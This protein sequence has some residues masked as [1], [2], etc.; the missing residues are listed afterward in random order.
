MVIDEIVREEVSFFFF[1]FVF[2]MPPSK[3]TWYTPL[4]NLKFQIR[5]LVSESFV[6][7]TQ[8]F[9]ASL[10]TFGGTPFGIC[11][12]RQVLQILSALDTT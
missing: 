5:R 7:Y 8:S 11:R 6:T 12:L 4:L 9:V 1:Q 2:D 10:P 3:L